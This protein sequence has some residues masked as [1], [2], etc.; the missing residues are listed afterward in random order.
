MKIT[1]NRRHFLQLCLSGVAALPLARVA[2]ALPDGRPACSLNP[3]QTEGP[4]YLDRALLREDITEGRPGQP[5]ILRFEVLD[6][7]TCRPLSGT[8]LEVWHCDAQGQYSGFT[9]M[10]AGGPGMGPPPGGPPPSG[11][12]PGPPPGG[13]PPGPP[14]NG[15]GMPLRTVATDELTF[16]RGVQMADERGLA[17]FRTIFPGYYAG[18]VNH[19]H[20]KLHVGG[21]MQDGHY[22]G[23]HT[24]HTGQ[25][26][27]PEEAS[28]AAMTQAAYQRHGLTRTTLAEDQV[29]TSQRGNTSVATLSMENGV[30][31]ARLTLAVDPSATSRESHA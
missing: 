3:E 6:S 2:R 22:R 1:W 10:S 26:F 18:R 7:R 12:P 31:T 13:T 16:L 28:I 17:G 14:P 9:A 27:F 23:G 24:V 15:D 11:R 20:L 19:I 30:Q 8:A 5:L 4:Y 29:Y 21:Q 25:L